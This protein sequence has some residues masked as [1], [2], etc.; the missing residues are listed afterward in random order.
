[1]SHVVIFDGV[2]NLCNLSVNILMKLDKRRRL[3]YS[4]L[5]GEFVKSIPID[6]E[7]D[8]IIFYEDGKLYYKS[9]AVLKILKALG[10]IWVVV[11][12]FYIIPKGIRDFIYDLIAKY[13]YLV[14]GKSDMCRMP[15]EEEKKLFIS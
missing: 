3:K 14:F 5:Q 15:T 12:V 8:S 6:K 2:C 10:G 1:M 4:P 11:N 7:V 13:R 9:D